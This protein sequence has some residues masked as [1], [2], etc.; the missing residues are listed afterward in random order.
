MKKMIYVILFSFVAMVSFA[1]SK[2]GDPRPLKGLDASKIPVLKSFHDLKPNISGQIPGAVQVGKGE[3]VTMSS[4]PM[5]VAGTAPSRPT[6][7]GQYMWRVL[8]A[9]NGTANWMWRVQSKSDLPKTQSISSPD[10]IQILEGVK[11][12]L[13]IADPK[14]EFFP[15]SAETDA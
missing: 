8:L 13:R 15:M 12:A 9:P 6:Q 4:G 2:H 3:L 5:Q 1:Q 10:G 14:T 7:I 11:T